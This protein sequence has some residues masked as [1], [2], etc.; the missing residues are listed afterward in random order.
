MAQ[1]NITVCTSVGDSSNPPSVCCYRRAR[2]QPPPPGPPATA[3]PKARAARQTAPG[4]SSA[5]GASR[6]ASGSGASSAADGDSEPDATAGGSIA[7]TREVQE[8]SSQLHGVKIIDEPF[9]PPCPKLPVQ[10]AKEFY[11][12]WKAPGANDVVGIWFGKSKALWYDLIHRLPGGELPGSNAI[13]K[14]YSSWPAAWDAWWAEGP[15]PRPTE[16]PAYYAKR[17]NAAQAGPVEEM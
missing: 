2:W 14:R 13:L 4:A 17:K 3:E 8:L 15:I 1:I 16:K 6:A 12:V 11:V 10:E 7:I 9:V 5:A